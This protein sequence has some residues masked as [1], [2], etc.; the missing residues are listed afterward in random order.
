MYPP[1]IRGTAHF[2]EFSIRNT[3]LPYE[4]YAMC[5]HPSILLSVRDEIDPYTLYAKL[6][7]DITA[8]SADDCKANCCKDAN[9]QVWQWSDVRSVLR[10]A[11][12]TRLAAGPILISTTRTRAPNTH[13]RL[14]THLNLA[15][16][17]AE[18]AMAAGCH[19]MLVWQ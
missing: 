7:G 4:V 10:I 9:C 11:F 1:R 6:N 19:T 15:T 8:Q 3:L 18:S 12:G 16:F 14:P 13:T 17:F 2:S 5:S